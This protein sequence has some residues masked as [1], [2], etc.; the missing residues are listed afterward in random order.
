MKLQIISILFILFLIAGC[1]NYK[2][3][4]I[5]QTKT[6]EFMASFN[7]KPS[8]NFLQTP[9]VIDVNATVELCRNNKCTAVGKINNNIVQATGLTVGLGRNSIEPGI[10]ELKINVNEIKTNKGFSSSS[11]G[12]SGSKE[13][14]LSTVTISEDKT[15][16]ADI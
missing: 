7:F 9:N 3:S 16:I 12:G 13:Y 4:L 11:A 8:S 5:G 15:T 1:T 6:G 2:D 10:Y 14:T